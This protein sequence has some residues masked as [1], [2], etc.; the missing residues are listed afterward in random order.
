MAWCG[1]VATVVW[2]AL[3]TPVL[4]QDGALAASGRSGSL[5]I[6]SQPAGAVFEIEGRQLTLTGRTPWTVSRGLEGVF[7][8]RSISEGFEEF[9]RTVYLDPS[10]SDTLRVSL[11]RKTP[12]RA[13][14][15]SA[16][17]PGWGQGYSGRH[18]RGL[19]FFGTAA[20]AGVGY[21]IFKD[22]YDDAASDVEAAAQRYRDENDAAEKERLFVAL[23]RER[24]QA[25]DADR[26]RDIAV[27]VASVVYA[28]NLFDAYVLFPRG[29]R[30]LF[31]NGPGETGLLAQAGPRRVALGVQLGY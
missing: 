27:I 14:W 3:A 2:L 7:M 31:V 13:L 10:S 18:G 28:A 1:L 12:L 20:A 8:V 25:D 17:I 29:G 15:R 21:L 30:E 16:L 11:T 9:K 4:A 22:R 5:T 6:Y 24:D 19:A 26:D 23:E